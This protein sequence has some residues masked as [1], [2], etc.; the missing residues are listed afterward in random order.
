VQQATGVIPDLTCLGKALASGMPLAAV[1][2]RRSIFHAGFARTHYC[3]T[4]KAEIYSLAA[5]KAAIGV[6]RSEP[7]ADHIWRT[8][9]RLK[10]GMDELCR[11]LGIRGACK[12]PPFRFSLVFDEPDPVQRRLMRTLYMQ[13]LLG[14]GLVTV[15]GV[16]L[17]GLAHSREDVDDTMRR[18]RNV[19][20]TLADASRAGDFDRRIEIPLL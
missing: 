11:E 19:L 1:A 6:Y 12:G 17:P 4:F 8:G 14:T 18:L 16:M 15:T 7:V 2:G 9:N 3:P 10:T 5:A 13:E 20:T